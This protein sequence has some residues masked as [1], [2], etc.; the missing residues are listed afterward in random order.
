MAFNTDRLRQITPELRRLRILAVTPGR[1][2]VAWLSGLLGSETKPLELETA[3]DPAEALDR[4]EM[5]SA[6]DICFLDD[7]VGD[8]AVGQMLKTTH[9]L[10]ITRE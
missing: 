5:G 10:G 9:A 4:I 1:F 6:F 7:A 2:H 3:A 8:R